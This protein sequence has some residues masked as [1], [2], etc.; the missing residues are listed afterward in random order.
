L[1]NANLEALAKEMQVLTQKAKTVDFYHHQMAQFES[2]Q[3]EH[4][5]TKAELLMHQVGVA[6]IRKSYGTHSKAR[7]QKSWRKF[8]QVTKR[9]R[10][11]ISSK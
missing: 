5:F 1:T 4:A 3:M 9:R 7:W 11:S 2:L 8:L 6:R 10:S